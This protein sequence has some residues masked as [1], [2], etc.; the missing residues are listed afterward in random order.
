MDFRYKKGTEVNEI[1][2]CIGHTWFR[3]F[4]QTDD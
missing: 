1:N 3:I 4:L 2:D